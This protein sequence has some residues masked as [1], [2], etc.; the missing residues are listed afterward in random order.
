M[1]NKLL[2]FEAIGRLPM[3]NDNVA[4]ATRVLP[5]GTGFVFEGEALFLDFTVLEGHRFAG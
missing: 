4:I 3:A 1:N 5:A 2:D